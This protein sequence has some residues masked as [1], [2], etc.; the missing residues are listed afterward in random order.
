MERKDSAKGSYLCG[1]RKVVQRI[2][3]SEV[4]GMTM[5]RIIAGVIKERTVQRIAVGLVWGRTVV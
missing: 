3:S 1:G 4:E 2:T 5:Q